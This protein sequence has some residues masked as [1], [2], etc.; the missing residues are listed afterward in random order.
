M[1][2]FQKVDIKTLKLESLYKADHSLGRNKQ[3]FFLNF[4]SGPIGIGMVKDCFD[5]KVVKKISKFAAYIFAFRSSKFIGLLDVL[6]HT[7]YCKKKSN[8]EYVFYT[9]GKSGEEEIR[10]LA[11]GDYFG[12]QALLKTDFRTANVVASSTT[13]EC[14]VLDRE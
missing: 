13:V 3:I 6:S 7:L 8:L 5:N 9:L 11:R 4:P 1:I 10:N 12:E 2:L 14:L